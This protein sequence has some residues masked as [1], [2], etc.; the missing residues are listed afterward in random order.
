MAREQRRL[1][2]NVSGPFYVEASCIDCGTCWSFD[3][4][5]F[6]NGT[7]QAE[8]WQQPAEGAEQGRAL[9][10]LQACPVAAIGAPRE[11]IARTPADG[12][13]A[14]ITRT[15]QGDVY[16]CGWASRLSFGASSYLIVRPGGLEGASNVLIDSPRF[17][18]AIARRLEALGGVGSLLLSHRDDVADHQAFADHFG[19]ERWIHSADADAAPGAEHRF[20]GREPLRFDADLRVLPCPGHTEG[21]VA[22]LFDDQV[23]FSGDHLWWS[24]S[25]GALVAS[26]QVCWWNWPEQVR[27]LERLLELDVRW[28]LPG[29]GGRRA[30]APGEWGRQLSCL[31][32]SLDS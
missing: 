18:R 14:L 17:N 21:S 19:C 16:Y 24:Q 5:H 11:L 9:L 29:H 22:F 32:D 7:Q 28:L 26:R 20:T 15:G 4:A 12:F 1:A 25:N 2:G 27:S 3:P 13:P 8:V 10:A 6:R 23:L 30:F 31:L